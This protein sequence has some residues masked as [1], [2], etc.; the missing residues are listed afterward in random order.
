M[1]ERLACA[2][3]R[4]YS[5]ALDGI[6]FIGLVGLAVFQ[7]RRLVQTYFAGV[8]SSVQSN[9][10]FWQQWTIV[11]GTGMIAAV[12]AL[13][14]PVS[15]GQELVTETSVD[16]D[17]VVAL[18]LSKSM[19]AEDAPPNRLAGAKYEVME[20]VDAMPDYRFA[21][22]GFAGSASTVSFDEGRWILSNGTEQRFPRLVVA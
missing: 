10:H 18:D 16:A 20:M 22:V 15:F 17:L 1:Y 6:G 9:R 14:Q 11:D 19:L 2:L 21:L 13:M 5:L 7:E 3:C 12:V 4:V 8:V